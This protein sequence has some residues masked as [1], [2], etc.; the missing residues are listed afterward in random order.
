MK[1]SHLRTLR[2]HTGPINSVDF[3]K[4][5]EWLLTGSADCRVCLYSCQSGTLDRVVTCAE[6]GVALTRFT[7]DPLSV[8][9]ASN[10]HA[11]RYTSLH[12]NRYLR[13]Y[14]GH[15]DAVTQPATSL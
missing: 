14:K 4:D 5:G 15:T 9:V 3:T 11:V 10:D 12:D 1:T 2:D 7:H 13:Y 8:I 6:H